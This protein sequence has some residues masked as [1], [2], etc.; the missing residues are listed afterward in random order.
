MSSIPRRHAGQQQFPTGHPGGQ[1]QRPSGPQ[2][3]ESRPSL[4]GRRHGAHRCRCA[5]RARPDGQQCSLVHAPLLG[6]PD[7]QLHFVLC[8]PERGQQRKQLHCPAPA[9]LL[10][11]AHGFHPERPGELCPHQCRRRR[12][13]NGGPGNRDHLHCGLGHGTPHERQRGPSPH[14]GS[15][16]WDSRPDRGDADSGRG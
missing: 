8:G 13:R 4:R 10:Q 3:G 9:R 5:G 16:P 14:R 15:W 12:R 11:P 1:R 2:C 7:R 6:G